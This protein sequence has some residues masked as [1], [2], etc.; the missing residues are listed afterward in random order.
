MARPPIDGGVVLVTGASSGIGLDLAK[1][2]APR[3]KTLVVVARRKDRL[4]ALA[5]EL[6]KAHRGLSVLPVAADLAR[7]D[8]VDRMLAEVREKAGEVD[9]LINN[10]GF[11]DMDFL[12]LADWD[13]TEKMIQL[14]V[15]AL[16]YL[17]H[18][19]LPSMV[20]KGRGG[21]LNISSGAGLAVMPSFTAYVAT[22]HYVT[23]LSDA[24]RTDLSGTGVVVTQSCPGPVATEFEAVAGNYSGMHAPGFVELSSLAC[25]KASLRAFDRG[26]ASVVPGFFMKVLMFFTGF[27]PKW[28]RRIFLGPVA[29]EARKRRLSAAKA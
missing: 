9:V 22:K 21:I 2:L 5:A 15:V 1:L 20:K 19:V 8:D 13:K 6:E 29:R 18:A 28:V 23:G 16:T 25:A 17:C 24:L 27:T 3:A 10:A 12:D 4:E 7:R 11:G 26:W 14:N